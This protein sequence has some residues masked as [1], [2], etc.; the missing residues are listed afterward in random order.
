M[1]YDGDPLLF[2][3]LNEARSIVFRPEN[4]YS[5]VS[6]GHELV[7]NHGCS[8]KHP[9]SYIVDGVIEYPDAVKSALASIF[10]DFNS[11][12]SHLMTEHVQSDGDY[13]HINGENGFFH[14]A[15]QI[16]MT[17]LP[18]EFLQIA[19][20]LDPSI[21][22]RVIKEAIYEMEPFLA[23]EMFLRKIS[24]RWGTPFTSTF[25]H[26][27]NNIRDKTGKPIWMVAST[28][29]KLDNIVLEEYAG[30]A[31]N[32]REA[33]YDGILA[34]DEFVQ[35]LRD[36]GYESPAALVMRTSLSAAILK[37][38]AQREYNPIFD[39][40][41][42]RAAIRASSLTIN[43][44]NPLSGRR[45][46]DTKAALP[47]MGMGFSIGDITHFINPVVIAS[48]ENRFG[49]KWKDI[50]ITQKDN[51]GLNNKVTGYVSQLA[52]E[53]PDIILTED[54][55]FYLIDNGYD[56]KT[57][58]LGQQELRAKPEE[59]FYGSI[60]HTSFKPTSLGSLR[61]LYNGLGTVGN[62]V[63]QPERPRIHLLNTDNGSMYH[64][65]HRNFLVTDG[66]N[67]YFAG[68]FNSLMP[69]DAPEYKKR[70]NHGNSNTRWG[71]IV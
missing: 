21:V 59:G 18:P 32:I 48:V 60:M 55:A 9:D 27:L 68:G 58:V 63:I 38:E 12:T 70:R 22:K 67:Y 50:I 64:S 57:I 10:H 13:R 2:S 29:S 54:F 43:V 25:D 40:H 26:V 56:P 37:G 6:L 3:Q 52:K 42:I 33:G 41:Q 47:L 7:L 31:R 8:L 53:N 23:R 45:M 14:T 46:N 4:Q 28:N 1:L 36:N 24:D 15:V 71:A 39:D 35:I 65:I 62:L 69:T 61:T 51:A 11:A 34:P 5:E 17:A 49:L 66:K 20:K 19:D 16:D 30:D 44:D